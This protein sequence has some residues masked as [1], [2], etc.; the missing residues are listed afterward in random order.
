MDGRRIKA[1]RLQ[2]GWTQDQLGEAAG[3]CS[4]TISRM[5]RTGAGALDSWE[6]VMT[7]LA[8]REQE[9]KQVIGPPLGPR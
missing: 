8:R 6:R 3:L 9:A 4:E 7:A 2:A 5:E 1:R